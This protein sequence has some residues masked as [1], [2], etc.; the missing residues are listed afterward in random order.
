MKIF[1]EKIF[2]GLTYGYTE[3]I[4]FF[5]RKEISYFSIKD[6]KMCVTIL[7]MGRQKCLTGEMHYISL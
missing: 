2:H 4:T 6:I 5:N 1:L 3:N 7:L